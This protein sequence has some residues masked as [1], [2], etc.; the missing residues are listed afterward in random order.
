MKLIKKKDFMFHSS[1]FFYL[2][3]YLYQNRRKIDRLTLGIPWL[4][5]DANRYLDEY[6]TKNLKVFE[7]G[8]G[9]STI[10][11]ARK[12][13]EL[14]SVE[15]DPIWYWKVKRKMESLKGN[16]NLLL[17]E[18]NELIKTDNVVSSSVDSRYIGYD[19]SEYSNSILEFKDA[20]FD[21]ILIDGRA[22]LECLKNSLPKIKEGGLIV[23]DNADRTKYHKGIELIKEN[24]VLSKYTI[25]EW[26]LFF[27]QTNIYKF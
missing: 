12:K 3:K 14:Y 7:F 23:F 22:R 25:V 9:S 13:V 4:T 5:I 18:P 26:D 10:F 19:Y 2:P 15:H 11:F 21:V 16:F 20:Y 27:S 24:C 17:K 8:S 1:V 6:V